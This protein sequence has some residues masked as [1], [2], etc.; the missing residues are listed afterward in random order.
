M[1]QPYIRAVKGLLPSSSAAV[2][3]ADGVLSINTELAMLCDSAV[4][5]CRPLDLVREGARGQSGNREESR[6]PAVSHWLF[7]D[8]P[9]L[10]ASATKVL[11]RTHTPPH[12]R[13]GRHVSS[14][15]L[16]LEAEWT[17]GSLIAGA[18][19]SRDAMSLADSA[20]QSYL[21]LLVPE[22]LSRHIDV[23]A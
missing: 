22:T 11:E 20:I 4:D 12:S 19:G 17:G 21:S 5:R 14:S 10:E 8:A 2:A 18:N 15:P 23:T 7:T 13:S 3:A 6:I 1:R 9:I 16:V